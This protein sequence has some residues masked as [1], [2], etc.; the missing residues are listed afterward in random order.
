[1]GR[2]ALWVLACACTACGDNSADQAT[3]RGPG[4]PASA[5][6]APTG[7]WPT[8]GG[9]WYNRRYSPLEQ[10]DRNNV[11]N[12]KGVWRARLDGSGLGTKYSGE[13]QPIV[14]DGVIYI[15]TGA[16]DV[17][18]LSVDTG[19][20][21][22]TYTAG[23]DDAIDTVCCGWTSRG[24]AV[25]D[26]RVY[27]G[28]LD[29]KLV[30]LDQ[31]TGDI[32]WSVQAERWEEGYTI[33]SAPLFY[34]GLV[35]T[36][37]AGAEYGIRGRVKAYNAA[38]GSLAWTFYTIP[39]PGEVGH[40]SWP[41]DNDLWMHGG[42]SVWQT[43]AVDPELG[44]V[45]FSTG[46]PGPDYN[47]AV[48]AGDNLFSASI[49]AVDAKT[50]EYRWHFQQVHHD[51][52]DF[53][54]PS[55]VV[56][57]DIEIDGVL[58]KGLAEA[59]KTG[60]VYVLDRRNGQPLIGI[61][62]RP[63]PQEP[64]QATSPTQP[65]PVGD[66]FAPQSLE[67]APEGYRLING[68][69]IFTPYWTDEIVIAKPGIGGGVN[70]PP[71]SYDPASGY[72]YVCSQDTIGAYRA[73]EIGDE[74]PPEGELYAAGMFGGTHMP[75]HGIFAAMDMHTNR[76]V[77]RQHW[78]DPC[79][80]GSV[81]TAGGLVFVGRSDGRLTALDSSNGNRL[82]TF[83][84]GAGMNAPASVFEHEG[85]QYV[86]AYSAGNLFAGSPKGDSVWLFALHGLLDEVP[87]ASTI[88]TYA[89]VEGGPDLAAGKL[90]YDSACTFCHGE[91][92]QGGHGGGPA[93]SGMDS[94]ARIMQVISEG[95][96]DMPSFGGA[97]TAEQAR[98]VS[99]YVAGELLAPP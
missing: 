90:V 49:V 98:D 41:G 26:G 1:M 18:A 28:Q 68:G 94:P 89:P 60:W 77:W 8:N 19:E 46:N 79:Y 33:T 14:L 22:W 15:V 11:A 71:S 10:I 50:G 20:K 69:Q 42:A 31:A 27:V 58:Q 97:L 48:R 35:I 2:A 6:A 7:S 13:A 62:E 95:R 81:V 30:A 86:V 91:A 45:Y 99:A 76:I 56:L 74:P 85:R 3:N 32:A 63:V 70:W 65:Y 75:D 82:W 78:P 21:L 36:G 73:E 25:G 43:P 80:S 16:D 5:V 59:S 38:D 39:G 83:Q 88:M 57:F 55:P 53:D 24:V 66:A 34:D 44:L 23:L 67:I 93:L 61:E 96:G 87:P 29:S 52:W 51:I 72:L 17:F 9:D 12:L 92:G 47:G 54:A 4:L 84:T 64:R 40:D 37:F